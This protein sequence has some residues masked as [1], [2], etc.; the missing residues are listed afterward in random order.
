MKFFNR[1]KAK[2][3]EKQQE[4][5]ILKIREDALQQHNFVIANAEKKNRLPQ[6]HPKYISDS[7]LAQ[8]KQQAVLAS[9]HQVQHNRMQV[10]SGAMG[11]RK[12][13]TRRRRGRKLRRVGRKTRRRVNKKTSRKASK[14]SKRRGRKSRKR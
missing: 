6:D 8:I 3:L 10:N 14:K 12:R 9:G 1:N 11:G 13:R 5:P 4:D 2:P 7:E